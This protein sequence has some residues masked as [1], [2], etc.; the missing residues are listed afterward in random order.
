[1]NDWAKWNYTRGNYFYYKLV[2]TNSCLFIWRSSTD[3]AKLGRYLL[4]NILLNAILHILLWVVLTFY[5]WECTKLLSLEKLTICFPVTIA[6]WV[7]DLILTGITWRTAI[8]TGLDT[9]PGGIFNNLFS[10]PHSKYNVILQIPSKALPEPVAVAQNHGHLR[11]IQSLLSF[12]LHFLA[13]L[14]SF[15]F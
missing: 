7:T 5:C 1:M 4:L 3:D 15:C 12:S 11:L 14:K 2:L 9:T 8:K 10:F 6:L 13:L